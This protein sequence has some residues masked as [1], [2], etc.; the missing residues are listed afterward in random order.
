[1]RNPR[2]Q[3]QGTRIQSIYGRRLCLDT[4]QNV[5]HCAGIGSIDH[6][7]GQAAFL[8]LPSARAC[9]KM[10]LGVVLGALWCLGKSDALRKVAWPLAIDQRDAS[11]DQGA[12]ICNVA[13]C[14][15]AP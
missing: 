1:M 11:I 5:C 8:L 6:T 7:C 10:K 12:R 9:A 3:E 13:D 15:A 14:M 2:Y 4:P